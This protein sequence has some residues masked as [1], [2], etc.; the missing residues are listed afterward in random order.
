MCRLRAEYVSWNKRVEVSQP[1]HPFVRWD[2]CGLR[3][4]IQIYL[5]DFSYLFICRMIKITST[6]A[7]RRRESRPGA[8]ITAIIFVY[9]P[10][11]ITHSLIMGFWLL[12]PANVERRVKAISRHLRK[13]IIREA[14]LGKLWLSSSRN[15]KG[16]PS[17][18][19]SGG[20]K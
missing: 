16:N 18:A 5:K 14:S 9:D 7:W 12:F 6:M 10:E 1:N 17:S 8:S 3:T 11:S 4:V 2:V 13:N 15:K 19:P 20:R